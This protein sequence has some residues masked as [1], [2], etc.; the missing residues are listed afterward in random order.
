MIIKYIYY[1]ITLR[2]YEINDT[3]ITIS[4][5]SFYKFFYKNAFSKKT[6]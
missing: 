4:N 2:Q 3:T 1:Y 6:L 5:Y